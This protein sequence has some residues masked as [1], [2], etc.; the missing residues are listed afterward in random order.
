MKIFG[1][2]LDIDPALTKFIL[3]VSAYFG[4][5]FIGEVSGPSIRLL[6]NHSGTWFDL[7]T[8]CSDAFVRMYRGE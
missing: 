4:E 7:V 1:L 3:E 5:W 8:E 6:C 2:N